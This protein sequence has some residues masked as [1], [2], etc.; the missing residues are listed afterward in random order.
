MA[1]W[2]LT[3]ALLSG[4]PAVGAAPLL[5]AAQTSSRA[6][7]PAARPKRTRSRGL[8]PIA[9][10]ED[11]GSGGVST[12]GQLQPAPDPSPGPA[13]LAPEPA[14]CDP[15]RP[16]AARLAPAPDPSPAPVAV[17]ERAPAPDP[18]VS[19]KRC[20]RAFAKVDLTYA[21]SRAFDLSLRSLLSA[22]GPP[23]VVD[24]PGFNPDAPP[25][26]LQAWLGAV[27]K[28]GG[29][30]GRQDIV[31]TRAFSFMGFLKKLFSA[32]L[33]DEIYAPAKRWNAVLW[34]EKASGQVRQVQ[35]TP[36]AMS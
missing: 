23:R 33:Q 26:R 22:D 7:P 15:E 36:R 19:A 3:L 5:V 11:K 13:P 14:P 8:T 30:I 24:T 29:T 4:N 6:A 21:D 20:D 12:A 27:Q 25:A 10:E 2:L 18:P 32:G 16:D 28:T 17:E 35:F 31:C 34:V 9:P 1:A